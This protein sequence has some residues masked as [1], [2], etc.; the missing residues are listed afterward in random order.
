VSSSLGSERFERSHPE[1]PTKMDLIR[2]GLAIAQ[3]PRQSAWINPLLVLG[4]AILSLLIVHK[5]SCE[6]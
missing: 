4:D 6:S 1:T 2:R 3:D 5:I